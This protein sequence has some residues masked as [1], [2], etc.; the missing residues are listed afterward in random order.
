MY[1]WPLYILPDPIFQHK[2]HWMNVKK[3]LAANMANTT[4]EGFIMSTLEQEI[5][6]WQNNSESFSKEELS[7]PSLVLSMVGLLANTLVIVVIVGGS[8]RHSVFMTLLIVLAVADNL[9]LLST[10]LLQPGVFG[11]IFGQALLPCRVLLYIVQSSGTMSSWMIV[12]ISIERFMAISYPLKVHIYFSMKRSCILILCLGVLICVVK[13]YRFFFASIAMSYDLPICMITRPNERSNIFF[14]ILDGLLYCLI[15]FCLI[16]ILN[17]MIVKKLKSI[18]AFRARSQVHSQSSTH[19]DR[20]LVPMM[21]AL[22]LVFAVTTFPVNVLLIT[23][24]ILEDNAY[25]L[26]KSY[27]WVFVLTIGLANLNHIVNFFLYCITGSVF[28]NAFLSL[29]K[30]KN[31]HHSLNSSQQMFTVSSN[32]I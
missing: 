11:H 17:V 30:C 4:S 21:L 27:N 14:S 24:L 19:R 13:V 26:N 9:V 18:K 23:S 10:D 25:E 5:S 7:V 20:S 22:S 15:P 31:N 1:K 6:K 2:L 28:R 3:I 12:L 29:F 8:L 16:S 32:P